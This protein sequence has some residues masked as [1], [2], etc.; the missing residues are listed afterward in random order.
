MKAIH[1]KI[2]GPFIFD[3]DTELFGMIAGDATVESGATLFLK[4]MI[5]GNLLVRRGAVAVVD[6]MVNG[7]V[8]NAGADVRNQRHYR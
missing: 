7:L 4:G 1:D 2:N 8:T 5:T 6:G 3:R